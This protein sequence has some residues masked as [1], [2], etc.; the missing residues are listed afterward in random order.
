MCEINPKHSKFFRLEFF[1]TKPMTKDEWDKL[2]Y[3]KVLEIE[4]E[5]NKSG[6][7][8]VHVHEESVNDCK[9]IKGST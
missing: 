1:T 2:I 5:F 9:T 7:I 3:S 4:Y 6:E 8:R